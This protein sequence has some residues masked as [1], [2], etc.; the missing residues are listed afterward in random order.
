MKKMMLPLPRWM[1]SF[2]KNKQ[3]KETSDG[4]FLMKRLDKPKK[5][6]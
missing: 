1:Y 4:L 3:E 2:V 5:Q 6:D